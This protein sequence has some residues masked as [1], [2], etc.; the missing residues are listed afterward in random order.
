MFHQLLEYTGV[1]AASGITGLALGLGAGLAVV[2]FGVVASV[3]LAAVG[4]LGVLIGATEL[5]TQ[6]D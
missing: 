4:A 3:P 2:S 6:N 5:C 1:A